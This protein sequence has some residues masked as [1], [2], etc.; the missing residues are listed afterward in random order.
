MPIISIGSDKGGAGK[1]TSICA[2]GAELA[3]DGYKVV[4]IDCDR[5]QYAAAYC[6]LA[7][8]PN[9]ECRPD[10]NEQTI[11]STVKE[12]RAGHE[13]VLIDLPGGNSLV[14]YKAFQQSHMVIMPCAPS[15]LDVWAAAQTEQHV[16]DA[17]EGIGRK[18]PAY[19]LWANVPPGFRTRVSR[20]IEDALDNRSAPIMRTALMQ[21]S[22]L[23]QMF[24]TGEPPR[25]SDPTSKAASNV[26]AVTGE[27]IEMLNSLAATVAN[28][29]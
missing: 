19:Y 5:N 6:D 15:P 10:V 28:A 3:L 27:L 25:I 26:A 1:T 21:W 24:M 18:I 16:A 12:A 11:L 23:K 7:K 29:R 22:L 4:I 8:I 17:A 13:F 2:I 20:A 14:S 9:L